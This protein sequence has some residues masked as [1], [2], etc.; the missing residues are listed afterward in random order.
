MTWAKDWKFSDWDRIDGA[1][2]SEGFLKISGSMGP[3]AFANRLGQVA[4]KSDKYIEAQAFSCGLASV[5]FNDVSKHF[6]GYIDHSGKMVLGPF[7]DADAASFDAD[8]AVLSEWQ[9]DGHFKVGLL[10]TRGRFVIPSEEQTISPCADHTFLVKRNGRNFLYD[11][12]GHV[13][14][15]FPSGCDQVSMPTHVTRSSLFGCGFGGTPDEKFTYKR[16]SQWGFCDFSG[17]MVIEP[18]YGYCNAFVGDN[19]IVFENSTGEEHR[20]GLIDRKRELD[21]AARI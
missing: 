8:V 10:N 6:A 2:F 16:G 3:L 11:R 9:K 19:S 21:S 17:R 20:C 4:F 12:S 14:I 13:L 5:R 7:E 1:K 15:K 18:K